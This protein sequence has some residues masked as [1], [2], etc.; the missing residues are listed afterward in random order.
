M[1]E[2]ISGTVT[3]VSPYYI[4]VETNGIGYQISVGN[5]YRYSGKE[6]PV[7]IYL[8]QVIREDAHTLYGFADLEEKQ[9]F[10]KLISVSGIG[11][12]S[13][14]AI[15]ASEDHGGLIN[16]IESDDA[17]YLTKFPGVGKK[18]AQQMIL[19]LKGKLGDLERSEAAVE[20]MATSAFA[21]SGNQPLEEAL[22]ALGALGY[23]EKEIKRITPKLEELE[24]GQ[25]DE[26]LRN[27][28]KLM[29]KR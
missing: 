7:K 18:T 5:P 14:L 16:A 6:E 19:D 10:L 17:A 28:L 4:V 8:H 9:L 29:M 20:A 15:M 2:Y 13:G 23:S 25:T 26:Y 27:A 22:E 1:Y 11:P 24:Q 21:G 12:K 3:Y